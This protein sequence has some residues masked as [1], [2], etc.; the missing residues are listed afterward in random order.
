MADKDMTATKSATLYN[1]GDGPR[2]VI[3]ADGTAHIVAPG[4]SMKADF[5]AG[6]LADLHPD[7]TTTKPKETSAAEPVGSAPADQ[8]ADEQARAIEEM[9]TTLVKEKTPEELARDAKALDLTVDKD[10]S[11]DQLALAIAQNRLGSNE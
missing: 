2:S 7:L 9:A 8:T 3:D 5:T 10:A 6:E 1:T 4:A 11:P